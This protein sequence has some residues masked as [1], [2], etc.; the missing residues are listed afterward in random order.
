MDTFT[1]ETYRNKLIRDYESC[2]FIQDLVGFYLSGFFFPSH[3]H[4]IFFHIFKLC[5]LTNFY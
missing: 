1:H 5:H 2:P 3:N 4:Y